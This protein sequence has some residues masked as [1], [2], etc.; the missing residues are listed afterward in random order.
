MPDGTL[1]PI[2]LTMQNGKLIP[3]A[4]I[5]KNEE[6]IE[7]CENFVSYYFVL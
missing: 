5:E 4:E 3:S 6:K 1:I 2:N 7:T